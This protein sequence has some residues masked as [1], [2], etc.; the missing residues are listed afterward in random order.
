MAQTQNKTQ[1]TS[2]SVN[3]FIGEVKPPERQLECKVVM[4]IMKRVTG[5]NPKMWGSS[6]VGYGEYHYTYDSG[7]EGD[8]LATGFS[9]RKKALTLY[10]M[11]G[12]QNY[13]HILKKLGPH[14]LGKS[15]LYLKKL[16]G[17][18]LKV[19]EKLIETGYK[20]LKKIFPVKK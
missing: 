8:S 1:K 7:R 20:D 18:D 15:C 10:I 6:I 3:D 4:K 14:T 5:K 13:E 17:I 12:Y 11:P 2:E 9:P 16:D 19:L